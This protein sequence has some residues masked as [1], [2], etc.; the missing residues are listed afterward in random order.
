MISPSSIL[1]TKKE[2][3]TATKLAMCIER[4]KKD[5]KFLPKKKHFF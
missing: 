3:K 2:P 5:F 4:R 1:K